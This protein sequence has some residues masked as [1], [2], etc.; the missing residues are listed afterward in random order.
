MPRNGRCGGGQW[1]LLDE[2]K[3]SFAL[4]AHSVLDSQ[5]FL[6]I[7]GIASKSLDS[8]VPF[9]DDLLERVDGG[10]V[11]CDFAG[12]PALLSNA[13]LSEYQRENYHNGS[14]RQYQKRNE[15]TLAQSSCS[16]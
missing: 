16:R 3:D 12:E 4:A 2:L 7:Q 5:L 8:N 10:L 15:E 9:V 11:A 14:Q 1:G 6:D 13:I